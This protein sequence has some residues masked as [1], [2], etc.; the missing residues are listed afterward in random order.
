M[1]VKF[2]TFAVLELNVTQS[3]TK[4]TAVALLA[5][6]VMPEKPVHSSDVALILNARKIIFAITINVEIHVSSSTAQNL[7]NVHCR[8]EMEYAIVCLD[9][10]EIHTNFVHDQIYY[11]AVHLTLTVLV[12]QL[13]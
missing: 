6:L 3:S 8:T 4:L 2:V 11:L 13:A 5:T 10:L 1:H 7:P 9:I 12:E